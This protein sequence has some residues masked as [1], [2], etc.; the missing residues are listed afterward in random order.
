M[1]AYTKVQVL[2]PG[3]GSLEVSGALVGERGLIGRPE[4]RRSPKEPRN[5]LR[6]DVEHFARCLSTSDALWVGGKDWK[7]AVPA[8]RQLSLLHLLD[9]CRQLGIFFAIR[10]EEF[11]PLLLSVAAALADSGCEVLVHAIRDEELR[12]LRPPVGAFDEADFIVAEWFAMGRRRV[13]FVG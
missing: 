2:A 8:S 6:K 4:V 1:F 3:R 10:G 7:V 5:I 13:L 11:R 9:L 12:V